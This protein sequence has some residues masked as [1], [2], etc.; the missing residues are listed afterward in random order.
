MKS[1]PLAARLIVC[2]VIGTGAVL[3]ASLFP[4]RDFTQPT[5][6]AV[7]LILSSVT[8]VFK[9]MLPLAR[10]GSTMSVS[11]AVDFAALLLLGTEQATL[12][13]A[14]GAWSQCTFRRREWNPTHQT[15]FSVASLAI[16]VQLAG[17]AYTALGGV[18]GHLEPWSVITPLVGA[19]TTY[20]IVNTT[21]IAAAVGLS[22][23]QRVE[24]VW[25]QNFL[26]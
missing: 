20:F 23:A 3:L 10:S 18:P 11:Y 15:L 8:S 14:V 16:T 22:T 7:M 5:L 24:R 9:V 21:L 25:N 12:I 1:L 26:W 13:A 19:T 6:F 2:A 4:L 17:L